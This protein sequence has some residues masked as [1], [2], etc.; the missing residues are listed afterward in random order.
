MYTYAYIIYRRTPEEN[1][2]LFT[3]MY[4]MYREEMSGRYQKYFLF[5]LK[6]VY[7]LSLKIIPVHS[8]LFSRYNRFA[9]QPLI[10][11]KNIIYFIF[12]ILIRFELF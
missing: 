10:K 2:A 9:E 8:G 12:I 11:N 3:W 7:Y 6:P 5:E 4:R 1:A